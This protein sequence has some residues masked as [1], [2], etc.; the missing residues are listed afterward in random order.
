MKRFSKLFLG[1]TVVLLLLWQLPWCYAFFTAKASRA[2]FCMYSCIID[3]FLSMGY[4][5]STGLVRRDQSG[6]SYTQKQTDSILP[7]FYVRQLMADER[8]P[9]SIRGVPVTPG[10]VKRSNFIYRASASAINAPSIPLHPLLESRSGRV[11]LTMPDDV[12]RITQSGIE[13]IVMNT[14]TPD[15]EKSHTFT[16]AL[17]ENGFRFPA[18]YVAG[19]PTT[20]KEYDEGY[21]L[22]DNEGKLFHLKQIKGSPYVRT[23]ALPEDLDAKFL[24][25]TEFS[26]HKTLGYITDSRNNFYVLMNKSYEVIKTGLPAYN[27][28]T[29]NLSVFGNK[30]DW[31]VCISSEQGEE[32]YALDANDYS[33]VKSVN[34]PNTGSS[35]SGLRFTSR[36]DKYVKPRFF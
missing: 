34:F 12:F 22:L 20:R 28:E 35:V 15:K 31:T 27:P 14:N 1:I 19:N 23:I 11:E 9:D 24:F 36:S 6:N 25:I 8:F 13:F 32:Y 2:P 18:R 29:D 30:F 21:L 10:E 16:E 4:D 7:M 5:E 3:D 17:K 33:L 26:D